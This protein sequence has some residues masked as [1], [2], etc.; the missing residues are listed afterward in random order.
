M[1]ESPPQRGW[2]PGDRNGILKRLRARAGAGNL[3]RTTE[4]GHMAIHNEDI[5][6][7]FSEI[8]DRLEI[9]GDNPFRIRAYRNAARSV[10][11]LGE[12]L[13]TWVREERDLTELPDIGTD[14]AKKIREI[15][16]TG[17]SRTLE[18]LRKQM[19]EGLLDLLQLPGLG[20]KRVKALYRNLEIENAEDLRKAA[21]A[22]TLAEL[23]GFGKKTQQS[24]L[25][26]LAR[27]EGQE[28]RFLLAHAESYANTL[29][30]YMQDCGEVRKAEFAGSY[31]RRKETVGDLDLLIA[32]RKRDAGT[33][34]QRFVDYEEVERVLA[35]G[36]TKSSIV[37][38]NGLQVDLR[39]L[40]E[41][42]FGAALHYFTGNKDHNI[43]LRRLGQQK[44]WKVSEYGVYEGDELIAGRTEQEVYKLF[45]LAWIPP[46]LREHRGEIEAARDGSLPDLVEEGDLR[47]DLHMH[48]TWSD[49]RH[50][51]RRMAEAARERGWDYIGITDHS[52]RLTVANGLDEGRLREQIREIRSLREELE[53]ITVLSGIEV[54]ILENGDLDLSDK[55]L[56]EL[57]FVV[58][59]IHSKFNLA[60]EAQT[61]RVLRA[62]DHPHFTILAHPTGR[63]LTRRDPYEI[64]MERVIRHAAERGCF[65][66]CNA[67][68]QRLDLNEIYCRMARDAGVLVSV[69]SDAHRHMDFDNLRYG[70]GQVR[71][72]WLEKDDVLNTRGADDLQTLL[73]NTMGKSA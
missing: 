55:V 57:D 41:T 58:A 52:R 48:S 50:S 36:S 54:D 53:G 45:D 22:G 23:E 59:S 10:E 7:V 39:V 72:G 5:A 18:N 1:Y 12:D 26:A 20:P 6:S 46:E 31:R 60:R 47:G 69:D 64:D 70:I 32:A 68:P 40:P 17:T 38:K 42:Q 43:A 37:L 27:W 24:V 63:L 65:L 44:G 14:L 8:G 21:E 71:R 56:G 61:E 51:I 33:I 15:V 28:K 3:E 19:P 34:M 73:D 62:M 29:L 11:D 67:H 35:H 16:E 66:E 25:E 9:K 4:S 30:E 49:G 2:T 13:A